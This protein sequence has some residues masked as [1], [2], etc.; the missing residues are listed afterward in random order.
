MLNIFREKLGMHFGLTG[1]GLRQ[2]TLLFAL[3]LVCLIMTVSYIV[4]FL[5]ITISRINYPFALEWMEGTSLVQVQRILA[6]K[7]LYLRP[8]LDYVPLI[9]PPLY[10]YS[11]ALLAQLIGPGFLP[12][13]LVSLFSTIGCMVLVFLLVR[14]I[15]PNILA[16]TIAVGLFGATFSIGGA[17]FDVA[18]VDMLALLLALL[19]IYCL[20]FSKNSSF[21][22]SGL[23]MALSCMTKQSYLLLL[24]S[25]S[26]YSY[27]L[28]RKKAWM[29]VISST[30]IYGVSFLVLNYIH[31]GWYK[32]FVYDLPY[33]HTEALEIARAGQLLWDLI[34]KPITPMLLFATAH[35]IQSARERK[36]RPQ[37][38]F[39]IIVGAII[40]T[41]WIG[42]IN[43]GSFNN[44]IVPSHAIVAVVAGIYLARN[45]SNEEASIF[46]KA[47]LLLV[48]VIQF[49]L[50]RYP[51]ADQIPTAED[52]RT[53][54]TL[55]QE[56]ADQ[57]GDVYVPYHP[58]LML[59][60]NKK[61]FADWISLKELKG[62]FGGEA[63]RKEWTK[64]KI[65]LRTAFQKGIFT[66]VIVDRFNF[67]GE[68][69]MYYQM[70]RIEYSDANA[71]YPVTGWQVRPEII[72]LPVRQS[73]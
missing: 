19:S 16:Q 65:Q 53:G 13:R 24:I 31:G 69:E 14:K 32:Y 45:L 72:Y 33:G 70:R 10:Y 17:W 7:P 48:A 49:S 8:S 41:S 64:L 59:F 35:F 46:L 18:R 66:M 21:I 12:L 54:E 38:G 4:I 44:V 57:P 39:F 1:K 42:L 9:Y 68:P 20:Q 34:M 22:I 30:T 27:F 50:L 11:A 52:L 67:Y 71:F 36:N 55:L 56:I 62:G 73:K 2:N 43:A 26:I 15:Q 40:A 3:E 6:G 61:T 29:F 5:Y 47:V 25:A 28:D 58:E 23:L 60:A 51:I 63:S 37:M